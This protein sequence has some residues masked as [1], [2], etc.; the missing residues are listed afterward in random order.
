MM[1]GLPPVVHQVI[2]AA[3]VAAGAIAVA[4]RE[5][6]KFIVYEVWPS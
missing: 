4:V 1:I 6:V 5:F 2:E 3:K